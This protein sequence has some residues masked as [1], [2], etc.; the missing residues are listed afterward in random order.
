MRLSY[1][2]HLG[3][4][5]SYARE[6]N[7]GPLAPEAT[8]LS[9]RPGACT[10]KHFFGYPTNLSDIRQICRDS[11]QI[12][13]YKTIFRISRQI[14]RISRQI[15]RISADLS[16]KSSATILLRKIRQIFRKLRQKIVL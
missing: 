3:Y 12:Q 2:I 4:G 14:C 8:T 6:S 1:Y 9:P 15:C 16:A 13:Y 11:R 5:K 10:I 7:R